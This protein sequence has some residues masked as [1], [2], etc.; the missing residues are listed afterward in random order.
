MN[1]T[2]ERLEQIENERNKTMGDKYFQK[3]MKELNVSQSYQDKTPILK[4][5]DMNNQYDYSNYKFARQLIFNT[6]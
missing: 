5:N 3:W 1:I 4:A 6:L 2:L